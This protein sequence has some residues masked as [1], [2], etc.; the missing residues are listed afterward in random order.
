MRELALRRKPGANLQNF[1]FC[2]IWILSFIWIW[3]FTQKPSF[4]VVKRK[5]AIVICKFVKLK[6][7]NYSSLMSIKT[8]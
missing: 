1:E 2:S 4:L 5:N 3:I 7:G 8:Q 6:K